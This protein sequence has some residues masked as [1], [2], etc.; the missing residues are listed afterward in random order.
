MG[1][2]ELMDYKILLADITFKEG[3]EFIRRNFKEVYEV[4]PGYKLFDVYLIGIPPILIGI[5][6]GYIIFPYV[7]PC[8]GTFVLKIKDG[9]D[10]GR[11]IKKKKVG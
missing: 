9:E 1:C 3:R 4:E 11:L 10:I 8:H 2:I 7:K 5:E 6:D